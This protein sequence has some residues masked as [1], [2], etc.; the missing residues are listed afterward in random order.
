MALKPDRQINLDDPINVT[1]AVAEA[2]YIAVYKTQP[3]GR[4]VGA[5]YNE[6]AKLVGVLSGNPTST[7][8]V[9]GV[10]LDDVVDIDQT[11]R[12]RNYHKTD[13]VV[14]EPACLLTDGWVLTNA[15]SGTPAAGGIAWV[16][17]NS[18]FSTTQVNSGPSCGWFETAKDAD[19]YAKVVIKL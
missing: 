19:G 17:A 15:I 1:D 7:T 16:G 18:Q 13:V 11:E 5:G 2:G 6:Q 12:H 4:A 9:A 8:R 10:F 3:S 14:G